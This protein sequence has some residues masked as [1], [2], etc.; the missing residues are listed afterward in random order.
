MNKN[1]NCIDF[2]GCIFIGDIPCAAIFQLGKFVNKTAL[3]RN[4]KPVLPPGRCFL[5]LFVF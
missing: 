5:L 4:V 3:E 1:N 2:K